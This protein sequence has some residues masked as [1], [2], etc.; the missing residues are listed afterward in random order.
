MNRA[1]AFATAVVGIAIAGPAGAQATLTISSWAPPTHLMTREVVQGWASEVEK[2]T[3]GRVKFRILAQHPSAPSGAFDAVREGLVDVS[4]TGPNYTPARHVV[5]M[6]PELPG[7]GATSLVNSVAYHRIYW[8]HLDKANEFKGV[9]LLST[10]THGPGHMFNTKRAIAVLA[11]TRGMKFRTGGGIGEKLAQALGIS[12]FVKSAPESYELLS[13]GVADGVFF[14]LESIPSFKLDGVVKHATL[15]P[16]GIY[17]VTFAFVMNEAAWNKLSKVDQDL[18]MSVSGEHLARRAG[19][20]WDAADA[21][22]ADQLRKAGVAVSEASPELVKEVRARGA[23]LEQEWIKAVGAKG[24]D[25]E[26]ALA[27]FRAEIEMLSAEK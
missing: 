9:R 24:V 14:P 26:K 3:E 25:G 6:L 21:A 5:T 13:S 18:V 4:F 19:K 16:G 15:F 20:A 7:G 27:E 11:D 2:A 22:A 23:H 1:F 17:N 12:S 8:K 10:F